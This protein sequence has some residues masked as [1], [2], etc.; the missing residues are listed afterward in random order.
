MLLEPEIS[1]KI[2]TISEAVRL[3]PDG[4]K[5][6]LGGWVINRCVI[7]LIHEMIRQKK[8]NLAVW[9][10]WK[11][12]KKGKLCGVLVFDNPL[13]ESEG[14]LKNFKS[15][16]EKMGI[17]NDQKFR[18][19]MLQDKIANKYQFSLTCHVHQL[20]GICKECR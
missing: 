3:I 10:N 8:R 6:A 16:L 12:D 2:K 14:V 17:P 13:V 1:D 4:A 9:V 15:C 19:E 20:F 5:V 18:L 11:V 7:A